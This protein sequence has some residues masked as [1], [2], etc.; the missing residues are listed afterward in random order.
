MKILCADSMKP[1]KFKRHL[2]TLHVEC[3]GKTSD[4]H[5]ELNEFNSQKQ[6]K[7]KVVPVLL[8][9]HRCKNNA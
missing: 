7:G 9:E 5:T 2:E 6:G 3:V 8:A 4:L 1:N